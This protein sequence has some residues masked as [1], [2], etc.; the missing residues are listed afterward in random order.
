MLKQTMVIFQKILRRCLEILYIPRI[1]ENENQTQSTME[2]EKQGGFSFSIKKKI[3]AQK[4]QGSSFAEKVV[5]DEE[6]TDFIVAFNENKVESLEPEEEEKELVIP[7]IQKNRWHGHD[8]QAEETSRSHEKKKSSINQKKKLLDGESMSGL[9]KEAVNEIMKETRDYN[10]TWN[11]RDKEGQTLT[12]PLLMVNKPPEGYETD[13]KLDVSIRPDEAEEADYDSVPITSFGMAMLRG[14]GW[15]ETEG[16]GNKMKKVVQPIEAVSRPKGQGLGAE[17]GPSKK[18]A[19]N[20]SQE[21]ELEEEA[22]GFVKGAGVLVK[23]GPHRNLYGLIEGF[24]EDNARLMIKLAIS[25]QTTTIS[26]FNA[27]AV[28]KSEYKKYAKDLGKFSEGHDV[29]QKQQDKEKE[30]EAERDRR[31]RRDDSHR[32][33]KSDSDKHKTDERDRRKHRD[34]RDDG[35]DDRWDDR[36]DD[37]EPRDKDRRRHREENGMDSKKSH[38]RKRRREERRENEDS[39][40]SKKRKQGEKKQDKSSDQSSNHWLRPD[41]RVRFI[42]RTYKSG[43]YYN[44]KVHVVDVV[45]RDICS[46][47]T[48]EG[49]LLED[50][51]ENMLETLIPRTEPGYIMVV[52]G[53]Y[54]GQV[55]TILNKDKRKCEADVQM[56]RDRDQIVKLSY[57]SICEYVGDIQMAEDL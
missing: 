10:E 3:P 18:K 28:S 9:D 46:C 44:T 47:R 6:K 52:Q 40:E 55:G 12:I 23:S 34:R 19:T 33:E 42:D 57:D 14:M 24:D 17:R 54:T 8:A 49:K 5:K 50:I 11:E 35:Y 4:L 56:L 48:D 16:I 15:K 53:K 7:L 36:H 21:G 32:K 25:G 13:D 37:K 2:T 29:L 41:L 30:R 43:R 20:K 27:Q 51:S 26:Q 39:D 45:R 22:E 31:K 1:M 38:D